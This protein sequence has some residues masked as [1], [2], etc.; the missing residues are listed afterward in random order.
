MQV[1]REIEYFSRYATTFSVVNENKAEKKEPN[2]S[3]RMRGAGGLAY[4]EGTA[5]GFPT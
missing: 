2:F 4:A 1:I 5:S 3:A